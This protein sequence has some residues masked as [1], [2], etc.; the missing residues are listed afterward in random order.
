MKFTRITLGVVSVF[1]LFAS[2]AYAE[3]YFITQE[4]A[5]SPSDIVIEKDV[6]QS[7]RVVQKADVFGCDIVCGDPCDACC[8]CGCDPCCCPAPWELCPRTC[9][10]YKIGGWTQIGYHTGGANGWGTGA[11]NDY[12]NVIQL[13]QAYLFMGKAAQ[14]CGCGFDWGFQLDYVYGTDGQDAQAF[15]SVLGNWDTSWD[16]GGFYGHALPQAYAEVAYNNLKVKAGHFYSILGY[17]RVPAVQ[18]FFYSHG[19]S[20]VLPWAQNQPKVTA[21]V[22]YTHTGFLAE[23]SP[24]CR[25]TLYGGW[26][27]GRDSGFDQNGGGDTFLGGFS[28][29]VSDA[30]SLD[31]SVMMGD[32][33]QIGNTTS[34]SDGYLHTVVF[35][36]DINCRLKCVVQSNYGDNGQWYRSRTGAG[37]GKVFSL[38][39]HLLYTLNCQWSLGSRFEWLK[40]AGTDEY[41]ELTLGANYRPHPNVILRPEFRMDEFDGTN[42]P[43][44]QSAFAIDAII[45][46]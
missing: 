36:W 2:T 13:Q 4:D 46:F 20:M 14:T 45:T 39:N 37:N 28:Y 25:V 18:N 11:F 12:P 34:D 24:N 43:Q 35:D 32:F 3:V 17:E 23:Y 5:P 41:A 22:P 29:A 40:M 21:V 19:F 31:Y 33:G 30:M 9:C 15:G 16:S 1:A 27:A 10:G 8:G 44:D 6:V 38:S 42:M 26:T 7:D